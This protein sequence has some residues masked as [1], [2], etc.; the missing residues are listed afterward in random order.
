MATSTGLMTWHEAV[1]AN[2]IIEA[3]STASNTSRDAGNRWN[4]VGT[5]SI[6]KG[7]H[8]ISCGNLDDPQGYL[9][10][11]NYLRGA[12]GDGIRASLPVAHATNFFGEQVPANVLLQRR[13][14]QCS[15]VVQVVLAI[16]GT[17]LV[18]CESAIPRSKLT[19]VGTVERV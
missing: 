7:I 5:V 14:Q 8:I 11:Q 6:A 19:C 9:M 1:A 16:P 15:I 4:S 2:D 17:V 3:L 12:I 18:D 13:V 10:E